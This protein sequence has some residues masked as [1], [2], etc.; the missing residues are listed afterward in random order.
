MSDEENIFK[1]GHVPQGDIPVKP[2][3]KKKDSDVSDS[4]TSARRIGLFHRARS[5]SQPLSSISPGRVRLLSSK[6]SSSFDLIQQH[7]QYCNGYI[8]C[9]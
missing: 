7:F 5:L 9:R 2:G 3:K 4:R 1:R 6:V 8:G